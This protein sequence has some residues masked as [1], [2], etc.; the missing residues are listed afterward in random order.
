MMAKALMTKNHRFS[1]ELIEE[2]FLEDEEIGVFM[3][4]FGYMCVFGV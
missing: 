4:S 3:C 1:R 2:D